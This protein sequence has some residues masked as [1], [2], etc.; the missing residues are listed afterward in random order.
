MD[1]EKSLSKINK[2]KQFL[3]NEIGETKFAETI[4]ALEII[5]DK[6]QLR[7][8][9]LSDIIQYRQWVDG[10]PSL[11]QKKIDPF[12]GLAFQGPAVSKDEYI[13]AY[14][15]YIKRCSK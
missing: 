1:P 4:T 12:Q 13:A 8:S 2:R 11:Q 15:T 7:L 5:C 3:L 6:Q 10:L 9:Q 14:E